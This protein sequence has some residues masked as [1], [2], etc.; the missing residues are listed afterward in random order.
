MDPQDEPPARP[1]RPRPPR[2]AYVALRERA[3]RL[4][5]ELASLP[6]R[7]RRWDDARRSTSFVSPAESVALDLRR[8]PFLLLWPLLRTV[9]GLLAL[10]ASAPA[11]WLALA[12]ATAGW[13]RTRFGA[14]LRRTAL[15]VLGVLLALVLVPVV[16]N[17]TVA[18]LALLLWAAEDVAD[19]LCDRLVVSDKRIYRRYG[20]LTRHSPSIALTAIAFIDAAVPPVGRAL[21]YGTLR[22]DSVAQRDAPLARLDLVPDVNAVSHEIL[23]L[24]AAALPRFPPLPH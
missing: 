2:L 17:R 10:V 21:G 20:V 3:V 15:V 12:L 22:L 4:R 6:E 13:T 1:A 7:G 19:W 5:A 23:R 24:R 9:A 18:A 8:H 11:V 16:A 14:G